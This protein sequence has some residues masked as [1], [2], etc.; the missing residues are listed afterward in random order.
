MQ[1]HMLV[2]HLFGLIFLFCFVCRATPLAYGSAQ[3]RDPI[4]ATAAGLHHSHSNAGSFTH[5]ARP[6]IELQPHGS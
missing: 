3:P 5:G 1:V 4:G 2:P 6:G